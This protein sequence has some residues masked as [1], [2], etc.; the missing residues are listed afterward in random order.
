MKNPFTSI[1]DQAKVYPAYVRE[2]RKAEKL[3][4]SLS[5]KRINDLM[6]WALQKSNELSV[7]AK[8]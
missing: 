5:I 1:T 2:K 3:A 6:T 7:K 4:S 8:V